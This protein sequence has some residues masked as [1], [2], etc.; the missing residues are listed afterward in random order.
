MNAVPRW[1]YGIAA[2]CLMAATVAFAWDAWRKETHPDGRYTLYV[3]QG[4]LGVFDTRT[5]QS[6]VNGAKDGQWLNRCFNGLSGV[7][8]TQPQGKNGAAPPAATPKNDSAGAP[9]ATPAPRRNEFDD[10]YMPPQDPLKELLLR[11]AWDSA[12]AKDSVR[13]SR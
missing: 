5:G 2:L 3:G 10:V 6:C 13:R 4:G 9:A 11:R 12:H 1:F 7:F 8:A